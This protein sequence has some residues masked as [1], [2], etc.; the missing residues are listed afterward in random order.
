[1]GRGDGLM[2]RPSCSDEVL[3]ADQQLKITDQTGSGFIKVVKGSGE[4]GYV[5]LHLQS[6]RGGTKTKAFRSNPATNDWIPTTDEDT[7]AL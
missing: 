7:E 5:G 6:G 2:R 4:D 3:D 1:M